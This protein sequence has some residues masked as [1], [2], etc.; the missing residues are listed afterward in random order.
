LEEEEIRTAHDKHVPFK[1]SMDTFELFSL[2]DLVPPTSLEKVSKYLSL[3]K[4]WYG[5]NPEL[6]ST[7]KEVA[8]KKT[9]Q[10][11]KKQGTSEFSLKSDDFV[12]LGAGTSIS[13]L[14]VNPTCQ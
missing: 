11:K 7:A 6:R 10:T 5:S 9:N 14:L 13:L 2:I 12:S 4:E 8:G 1:L 3:K